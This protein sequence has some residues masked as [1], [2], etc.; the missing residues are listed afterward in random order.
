MVCSVSDQTIW[1][2][3]VPTCVRTSIC[4]GAVL[5]CAVLSVLTQ[6]PGIVLSVGFMCYGITDSA[7]SFE[8]A[9]MIV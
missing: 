1:T 4:G 9:A 6:W 3:L 5:S 2:R 8:T 7:K